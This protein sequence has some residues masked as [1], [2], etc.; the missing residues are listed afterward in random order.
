MSA[1]HQA[2]TIGHSESGLA[3]L[4][5]ARVNLDHFGHDVWIV[6]TADDHAASVVALKG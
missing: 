4:G 5:V 1:K 2:A 3:D 6:Y